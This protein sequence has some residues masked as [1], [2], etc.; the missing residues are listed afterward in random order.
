MPNITSQIYNV[1][2]RKHVQSQEVKQQ[3]LCDHFTHENY[4]EFISEASLIFIEQKD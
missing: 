3:H 2:C 1:R 4:G